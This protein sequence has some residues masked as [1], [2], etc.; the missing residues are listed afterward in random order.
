MFFYMPTKIYQEENCVLSRKEEWCA[1][2]T[3][4]LLV[5]GK[6]SARLNG[7]L[8]DV[9]EALFHY[10]MAYIELTYELSIPLI[11]FNDVYTV[12]AYAL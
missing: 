5:T 12:G 2:G 3:R 11:S 8:A 1:L 10:Q 4:A 7:A 9:T 6:N